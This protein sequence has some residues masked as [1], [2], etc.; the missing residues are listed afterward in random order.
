MLQYACYYLG[1]RADAE[2]AVQ[3]AF[4]R[5]HQRMSQSELEEKNL[6]GYL[7]RTLSNLCVSRLREAGR[8]R[9]IPLEGQPEPIEPEKDFQEQEYQRICQLLD[10]IPSEQAEVIRMR[11]YGDKSFR[12]IADIF[13]LPITTVK[14]RFVYGLEK[15]RKELKVK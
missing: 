1:N 6:I 3:D 11:Y 10:R 13:G 12:E 4:V 2:D 9:M 7:Y 14:S 5:L 15:I 8:L